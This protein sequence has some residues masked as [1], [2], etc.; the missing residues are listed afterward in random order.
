[1][2]EGEAPARLQERGLSGG[3]TGGQRHRKVTP[4]N[5]E[6]DKKVT[7]RPPSAR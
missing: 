5:H 1:M 2:L 6:K 4:G 3:T 7:L